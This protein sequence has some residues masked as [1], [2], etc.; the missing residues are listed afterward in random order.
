MNIK[1]DLVVKLLASQKEQAAEIK[2]TLSEKFPDFN[3]I[4]RYVVEEEVDTT[5]N[6]LD[7]A[8]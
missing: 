7:N 2:K 5:P 6:E 4:V 8:D 1:Q 3:V